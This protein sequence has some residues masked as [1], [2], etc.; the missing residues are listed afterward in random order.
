MKIEISKCP[1][2][3]KEE[4]GF[5]WMEHVLAIPSLLVVVSTYKKNDLANATLQSWC[6]FAGEGDLVI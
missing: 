3:I 5:T 6:T 2:K 4:Y 1:D